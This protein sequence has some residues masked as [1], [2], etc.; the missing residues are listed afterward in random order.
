MLRLVL[1]KGSL[2]KAT[3]Q[4]FEEAD[5]PE[6]A[7]G[8]TAGMQYYF[9]AMMGHDEYL[10]TLPSGGTARDEVRHV[11]TA[12]LSK[13]LLEQRLRLS[14]FAF[15]SPSDSDAYLRPSAS[16]A[17]DDSWTAAVGANVFVGR[18]QHTFFGQFENDSN[19]FLSLRMSF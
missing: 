16:Y 1:P 17:I 13:L 18:D 4:L 15:Y 5:L 11:V 14:L 7:H 8:L 3:L 2:E 10:S 9:E 19:V 12:R 6:L